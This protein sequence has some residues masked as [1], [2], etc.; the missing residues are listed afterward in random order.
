MPTN[1]GR[2]KRDVMC[3]D[4]SPL[5]TEDQ[6]L[7][8][9]QHREPGATLPSHPEVSGGHD[10]VGRG[11]PFCC[12]Q[13]GRSKRMYPLQSLSPTLLRGPRHCP[14]CWAP[15]HSTCTLQWTE[16]VAPLTLLLLSRLLLRTSHSK[17]CWRHAF[18]PSFAPLCLVRPQFQERENAG[19]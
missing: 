15:L 12:R 4:P 5:L 6:R 9:P 18:L 2:A 13:R 8:P 10:G 11:F 1:G 3:A 16:E 19:S 7:L 14:G 17:T